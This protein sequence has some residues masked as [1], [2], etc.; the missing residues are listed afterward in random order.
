[1][2]EDQPNYLA[3]GGLAERLAKVTGNTAEFHARQMRNQVRSGALKPSAF[4]G[5]G[6]TAAALFDDVGIARAAILHAVASLNPASEF[7]NAAAR[8]LSNLDPLARGKNVVEPSDA[9]AFAVERLRSGKAMFLHLGFLG[10]PF[11]SY[12]G[13]LVGWISHTRDVEADPILAR[14]KADVV[15]DLGPIVLPLIEQAD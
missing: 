3:I 10:W 9:V 7:V 2:Q 4:G 5:D 8:K 1:M 6:A 12:F 14:A 13:E 15:I 11:N